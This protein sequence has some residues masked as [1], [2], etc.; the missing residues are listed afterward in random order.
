MSKTNQS[1]FIEKLAGSREEEILRC[2]YSA[3]V[4][5]CAHTKRV[6]AYL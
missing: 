1:G 5:I 2:S 3:C 4:H 6:C